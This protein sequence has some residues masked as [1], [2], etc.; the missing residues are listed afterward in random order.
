VDRKNIYYHVAGLCFPRGKF[1]QKGQ[2][3]GYSHSDFHKET[4]LDGEL[5]LDVYKDGTEQAKF[6]VFDAL[7]VDGKNLLNRPLDRRLGVNP[8]I[9]LKQHFMQFIL[10]P[11]KALLKD[12]PDAFPDVPFM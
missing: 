5:V 7:A 10:H 3:L 1:N 8:G 2:L 6:L 9:T 12:H 4:L 11:Y